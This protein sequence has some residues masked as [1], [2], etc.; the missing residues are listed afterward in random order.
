MDSENHE[1]VSEDIFERSENELKLH[2]SYIDNTIVL[3]ILT[4][5]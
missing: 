1:V 5:V 2:L 3:L 4:I